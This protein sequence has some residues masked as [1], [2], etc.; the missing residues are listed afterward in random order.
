MTQGDGFDRV[1][2]TGIEKQSPLGPP[3]R[4]E[5]AVD[6]WVQVEGAPPGVERNT[7]TGQMRNVKEPPNWPFPTGR[8]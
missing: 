6:P 4:R 7:Q 1:R 2:G 3:I 8:P 5:Q